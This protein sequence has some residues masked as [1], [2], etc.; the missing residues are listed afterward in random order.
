MSVISSSLSQ[1]SARAAGDPNSVAANKAAAQ[2]LLF[3]G[4]VLLQKGQAA[5]ALEK[6]TGARRLFPSP[7][8]YYNIGQAHGLI[9]G[10]EAES[11]EAMSHFL[12]EVNDASPDLRK[13]AEVQVRTLRPK[14][15]LVYVNGDPSDSAVLVD[16]VDVGAPSTGSP[17]VLSVGTH[18]LAL[19]RDADASAIETIT[20]TG[21]ETFKLQLRLPPRRVA[22][23]PASPPPEVTSTPLPSPP[24]AVVAAI[25]RPAPMPAAPFPSNEGGWS[26]QRVTGISLLGVGAASLVLGVIEHVRYFGKADDFKNAGCGTSDLAAHSGCGNLKSQFDS[27][28]T[29]LIVGYVGAAVLG[30]AGTYLLWIAPTKGTAEVEAR[31]LSTRDQGLA[32]HLE[33]HF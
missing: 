26:W 24:A 13:A 12:N 9:P 1:P 25:E 5:N 29:W 19:R 28:Q 10:H 6:F 14:V 21:G 30:G 3:E 11:Y 4:N 33:G 23:A 20:V 15:A 8:I 18:R 31:S 27:A 7:K 2:A 32:I 17:F 22:I 16:D